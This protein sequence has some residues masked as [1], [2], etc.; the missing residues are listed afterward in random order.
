MPQSFSAAYVHLVFST[1]NRIVYLEE[2]EVRQN[3]HAY[4][5]G[6]SREFGCPPE[7]V[8]G[9]EDHVHVLARLGRT[10][11]IADWVKE[12]KRV[13]SLWMKGHRPDFS[14]QSGYAAFSVGQA[15]L[16]AVRAYVASQEEHHKTRSFQDEFRDLLLEHSLNWDERYVWD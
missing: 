2:K 9:V 5:G 7:L 6:V 11:A 8:G 4:M 13:S 10:T 16:P 15:Q 12:L 14:W 1:K 3:L